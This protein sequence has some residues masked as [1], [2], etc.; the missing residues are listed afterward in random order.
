[1]SRRLP[2][3]EKAFALRKVC[4]RMRVHMSMWV[5]SLS[6]THKRV[7]NLSRGPDLGISHGRPSNER[8]GKIRPSTDHCHSLKAA[9]RR[10][11]PAS[12]SFK[13]TQTY[14]SAHSIV[15]G[16]VMMA[17]QLHQ[18]IAQVPRCSSF[19]AASRCQR[20]VPSVSRSRQLSVT[21]RAQAVSAHP[22]SQCSP[23]L[24]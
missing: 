9:L 13:Q 19:A 7:L 20:L 22:S 6:L 16:A 4:T 11:K 3:A 15:A 17:T 8:R 5:R 14:A 24:R 10:S 2:S 23:L 21:C 1:M 12:S 18:Q